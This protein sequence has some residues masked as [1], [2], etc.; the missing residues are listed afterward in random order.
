MDTERLLLLNDDVV[1]INN[2]GNSNSKADAACGGDK[3]NKSQLEDVDKDVNVDS[4]STN[5]S[6]FI[7]N[8]T[9]IY[10]LESST[11]PPASDIIINENELSCIDKDDE[12]WMI[13]SIL[14]SGSFADFF[15]NDNDDS[16][17]DDDY[18]VIDYEYCKLIRSNKKKNYGIKIEYKEVVD[19]KQHPKMNTGTTEFVSERLEI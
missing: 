5:T 7:N 16:D 4:M 11:K 15:N 18:D 12:S 19:E 1:D 9:S 2:I 10:F 6:N 14:A 13:P 8:D 17:D 3:K